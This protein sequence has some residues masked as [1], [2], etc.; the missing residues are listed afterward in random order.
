MLHKISGWATWERNSRWKMQ[1]DLHKHNSELYIIFKTYGVISLLSHQ[2]CDLQKSIPRLKVIH[3][4]LDEK[5]WLDVAICLMMNRNR[6]FRHFYWTYGDSKKRVFSQNI[7][8]CN[9]SKTLLLLSWRSFRVV[10]WDEK[11]EKK[12][13]RNNFAF[14][15]FATVMEWK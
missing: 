1:N 7:R 10:E 13:R 8:M 12:L 6:C 11:E 5:I 9:W 3:V 2:S 14:T 15:F 4:E